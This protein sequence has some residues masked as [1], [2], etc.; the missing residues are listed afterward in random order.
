MIFV[1][2]IGRRAE[3]Q[4]QAGRP[5]PPEFFAAGASLLTYDRANVRSYR[6]GG[7]ADLPAMIGYLFLDFGVLHF[8][9]EVAL[10]H[11]DDATLVAGS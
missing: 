7:L 2:W 10:V 4:W 11:S 3:R 9:L 6:D 8:P 1:R 5:P